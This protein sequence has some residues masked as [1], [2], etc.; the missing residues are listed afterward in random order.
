MYCVF[1]MLNRSITPFILN[2]LEKKMVMIGGPRQVGKS[3]LAMQ[4]LGTD[5]PEHPAYFNWDF[6]LD[7]E[8]LLRGELPSAES[9]ILLDEIHKYPEWRNLIKGL[10]DKFKKKKKFIIT[11]SAKL[12]YYRHG[13][14]ALTGRYF[15]YRLH[16]ISL[17]ELATNPTIND[18]HDLIRWGGF[19]AN[20]VA[21]NE[22]DWKRWHKERISQI[23][24]DDILEL[25]KV[26]E[27]SH[28]ML[29][30]EILPGRASQILSINALREDFSL[31]HETLER[32]VTILENLYYC[33]RIEPFLTN[34]IDAVK[35]EKKLYLWDWSAIKNEGARLENF[36]A[37][38]LL[39]YCH[40]IEDTQ[41]EK[42]ELTFLKEKNKKELDFVVL[43]NRKPLFAVECKSNQNRIGNQIHYF[44]KILN[45]PQYY[46]VHLGMDDFEV[47]GG[48]IRVLPLLAFCR[49]ILA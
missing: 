39:R 42:M 47:K 15:H 45:I 13:G 33:F 28:L 48:K 17:P 7:K 21:K 26:K 19:P 9:V 29:L 18:L 4:I 5:N 25:E 37:S 40:F 35:K 34:K 23:V 1:S 44:S 16:P 2:D 43:K 8:K 6:L 27:V 20:I 32:Y 22:V 36:V 46:Q 38:C 10:Y 24:K 30:A 14:D 41:G 31:A 12:D 3:T 49:D 11:G